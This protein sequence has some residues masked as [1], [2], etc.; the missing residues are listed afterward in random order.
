MLDKLGIADYDKVAN[1]DKLIFTISDLVKDAKDMWK[2]I[3]LEKIKRLT[4]F[5]LVREMN[6]L[7][8]RK[9][10]RKYALTRIPTMSDFEI[11][12]DGNVSVI[13]SVAAS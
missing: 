2:T 5:T 12:Q 1:L 7:D 4:K 9:D 6:C 11:E 8:G 10:A 13:K 3:D